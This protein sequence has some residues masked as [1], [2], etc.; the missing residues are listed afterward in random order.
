VFCKTLLSGLIFVA[1]NCNAQNLIRNGG[2]EEYTQCPTTT[3]QWNYLE[4]WINPSAATPNF[5]HSCCINNDASVPYNINSVSGFQQAFIGS[6]YCE[7]ICFVESND[8]YR[9]YLQQ[10][11]GEKLI[12]GEKYCGRF[13]A[14]LGNWCKYSIDKLGMY[15]SDTS[16]TCSTLCRFDFIPQIP[17]FFNT[18]LD[19]TLNWIE[20]KG[21]FISS[22]NERYL[23]IGNFYSNSS[24]NYQ[25]FNPS[26]IY[27]E[28]QYYFDNLSLTRCRPPT[29]GSDTL[30]I[31]S[32]ESITIGDTS[33]DV[34]SYQ[35]L[36][37]SG[38]TD[39]NNWQTLCTAT[40]TTVYTLQKI[41]PCDTTFATQT[42]V[43]HNEFL[44]VFPNPSNGIV[45]YTYG[46]LKNSVG[47]VRLVDCI[48]RLVYEE[49]LIQSS[50]N[51]T[52]DLE[53]SSGVYFLTLE[54]DDKV[55]CTKK[56][57]TLK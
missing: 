31:N 20:L 8:N 52:I 16:I 17:S 23:T 19:D 44:N 51:K 33:Q 47:S 25:I 28:S 46:L 36:P 26:S 12:F 42:I 41:T 27:L 4:N 49:K 38:L 30:H 39:P 6:G 10:D 7:L 1:I 34:A 21:S 3:G 45:S 56:I 9:D 48:G 5:F 50:G 54:S 15:L 11:F 55:V 18:Q 32:G 13:F 14:N 22:G 35:W 43:V 24:S 57:I 40:E 53:L 2:F 37:S 29:L